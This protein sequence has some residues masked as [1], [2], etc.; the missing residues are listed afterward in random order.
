MRSKHSHEDAYEIIHSNSS[1]AA[2]S[3][4]LQME[5][6]A[7]LKLLDSTMERSNSDPSIEKRTRRRRRHSR[8]RSRSITRRLEEKPRHR[9]STSRSH[10]PE[11][12]EIKEGGLHWDEEGQEAM[13][14]E[15]EIFITSSKQLGG[16]SNPSSGNFEVQRSIVLLGP[17]D[18]PLSN[19]RY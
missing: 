6:I 9:G 3:L 17:G 5:S 19:I 7:V 16:K 11:C 15:K 12:L 14:I 2:L 4:A 1:S 8:S 10:V 18:V 13:W